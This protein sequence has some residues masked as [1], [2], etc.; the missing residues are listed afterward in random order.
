MADDDDYEGRRPRNNDRRRRR[1]DDDDDDDDYDDYDDYEGGGRRQPHRGTLI[2]VLGILSL[3]A[4]APLGIGAWMMG[5]ADLAAM[6]AGRM[7]PSGKDMTQIGYILGIIGTVLFL[8]S[9]S[10]MCLWFVLIGA[11]AGGGR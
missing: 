11:V 7:D 1:R 9:L 5:S 6:R 3:V 10:A 8:L 2:V 4:C